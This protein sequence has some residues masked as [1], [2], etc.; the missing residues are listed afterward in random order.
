MKVLVVIPAYNE[1]EIILK[2]VKNV[3]KKSA[4]YDYLVIN[5]GSKDRTKYILRNNH[6]IHLNHPINLG[7]A[8]TMKTGFVYAYKNNY[9]AVIQ[10]DGDN[11]HNPE[12]IHHMVMTMQEHNLDLVQG[13]RFL[14][15]DSRKFSM[16]HIG[17]R[18]ISWAIY[19]TTFTK[20]TD[21]TNGMRL[22]GKKLIESFATELN[23]APEPDTISYLIKD[24]YRIKEIPVIVKERETGES[25]LKLGTSVRYMFEVLA[26]ILL[27]QPF[28]KKHNKKIEKKK[29]KEEKKKTKKEGNNDK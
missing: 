20:I 18:L 29:L 12:D 11:Q 9:D 4:E 5:D 19:L 15:K 16:R 6:V 3:K 24:K 13:S 2:T 14:L 8:A 25:Y 26:S 17:S 27:I 22:Y 7:L 21:P 10:I 28:R 1:E 23:R